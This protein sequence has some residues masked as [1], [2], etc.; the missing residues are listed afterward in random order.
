MNP[1]R[2]LVTG[3]VPFLKHGVNSS[4]RCVER[5]ALAPPA[6]VA[7]ST[8]VLPVEFGRAFETL[9]EHLAGLPTEARPHAIV[10]TGMA[11]GARRV[12][13]ERLGVNLA[14]CEAFAVSGRRP[15]PRPDNAGAAPI[16]AQLVEGGALALPARADVKALGRALKARGLPVELSLSAGSYVCNDLYYRTLDHL[17]RASA[18]TRCLFVH[19]PEIAR[20]RRTHVLGI[21]VPQVFRA[22]RAGLNLST[23]T[24]TLS[25]LC[26][27]LS[28]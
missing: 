5:L 23:M 7:L 24:R 12:R 15:R 13:L 17:A 27:E 10:L 20:P 14:D 3:F 6:D 19:L 1:T 16:D 4:Q 21:P 11:A 28:R 26:T 8:L 25:A 18:G 2:I 9:R 22:P